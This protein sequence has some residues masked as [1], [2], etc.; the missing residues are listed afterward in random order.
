[1]T[2]AA[3]ELVKYDAMCRAIDAAY[4]VDEA[5][6]I[7]DKAIALEVY[8]RQ[9]HNTEAERR[10][11][12]IRLRAERKAGAISAKLEKAQGFAK[13]S[14]HRGENVATKTN[15][16]E[17]AGVSEKQ[18]R[19]WEKLAAVPQRD[20]DAALNDR[21]TMP[22]TN[23]IIRASA[24][25]KQKPETELSGIKDALFDELERLTNRETGATAA[26]TTARRANRQLREIKEAISAPP[27]IGPR[28][29]SEEAQERA[30]E[31]MKE[32]WA[33]LTV[34]SQT[35]FLSWARDNKRR[36]PPPAQIEATDWKSDRQPIVASVKPA[37]D[38]LDIPP[39]FRR[40]AAQL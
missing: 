7:R 15:Q 34:A 25:P 16:L 23:G 30:I 8:A 26:N 32:A 36:A 10:A 11:C 19:Q 33:D 35:R 1:M 12:E 40:R 28:P 17:K 13:H 24:E 39:I 29:D 5:K 2:D 37:D 4:E 21:T 6:G 18:A 3:G 38:G 31:R 22:T 20:F 14:R 27:D 9:A